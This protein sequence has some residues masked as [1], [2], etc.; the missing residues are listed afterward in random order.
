MKSSFVAFSL[1]FV[2]C[3]ICPIAS[4]A[5]W[6]ARQNS[7][8]NIIESRIDARK[9][10]ERIKARQGKK[11]K[12]NASDSRNEKKAALRAAEISF[13]VEQLDTFAREDCD[14]YTVNFIF[15]PQNG[16]TPIIKSHHFVT[17]D[18]CK[19]DTGVTFTGFAAGK[20]TLSAE[21]VYRE[22]TKQILVGTQA[23]NESLDGVKSGGNFKPS[24][25]F[26]VKAD[27]DALVSSEKSIMFLIQ[28]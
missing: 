23:R 28:N 13:W 10:A 11:N 14:G 21:V 19:L 9:T 6:D 12:S 1:F 27:N 15:T 18:E 8:D 17:N 22:Q 16:G 4:F 24:L 3:V 26:E 5:Q 7:I 2:I 25:N 20:Y